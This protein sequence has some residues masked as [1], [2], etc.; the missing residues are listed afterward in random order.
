M[1]CYI[2]RQ[3]IFASD[4]S[5]VAYELLYRNSMQ[6]AF[7]AGLSGDEAT[8]KVI[9][10]A[11][12]NFDLEVLTKGRLAFI[13]FTRQ[14]L[15]DKIPEL[16]SPRSFALEILENI[17]LDK[18]LLDMLERYKE[19]GFVLVLD[20]YTGTYIP[21]EFMPFLDIVK[22]DF[23]ATDRAEQE[24]IARKMKPWR[25]KL[26]AEKVENTEDFEAAR[27]FGYTLFQ[28]YFFS[29]PVILEKNA[30][31][32]STYSYVRLMDEASKP[33]M[34]FRKL[35]DIIFL[36]AHLTLLLMKKM[37]TAAYYRGHTVAS[38][39][40]ALARMGTNEVSR[41]ITLLLLQDVIG[42]EMDE[43][44]RTGLIRAVFCE[45]LSSSLPER[46]QKASFSVGMFSIIV[47]SDE[48]LYQFLDRFGIGDTIIG[49]LQGTNDLSHCLSLT[50][51]YETG[52]WTLVS[53]LHKRY[54][55]ALDAHD[56]TTMYIAAV[57]YADN[58]LR[59]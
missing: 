8:R 59:F 32:I 29:K 26:L 23:R 18:P 43:L 41:W 55:P 11:L 56:L 15:L 53:F 50:R 27:K 35:A 14:L 40:M 57:N 34:S 12:L 37:R 45:C 2:A 39:T 42:K 38:I 48:S 44:V 46:L 47:A 58:A 25:I 4:K 51:A 31:S 9:I 49:A 22:V 21:D 24:K 1:D 33:E 30:F 13:N 28:G 20:D 36:D 54:F 6:N 17:A 52:D 16:L 3:P 5:L 10:N 19:D 7:P